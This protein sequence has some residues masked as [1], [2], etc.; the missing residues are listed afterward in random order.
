MEVLPLV[1][2]SYST[3][4][5][6]ARRRNP[7]SLDTVTEAAHGINDQLPPAN[8]NCEAVV[9]IPVYKEL[10][11]GRILTTLED[12]G[13]Q[14]VGSERFEVILV[15]NNPVQGDKT[16]SSMGE[17]DNR[18]LLMRLAFEKKGGRLGNVHAIDCTNGELPA[19]HIGLARGL[20][21]E[22]AQLRLKQTRK[23][24]QGIVVQLDADVAVD[25]DFMDLLITNYSQHPDAESA[26]IRRLPLPMDYISDDLYFGY[27][28]Y[29]MGDILS[30]LK[31]AGIIGASGPTIS[32]KSYLQQIGAIREY[33]D[34]PSNEDYL[35]GL[36]LSQNSR[37]YYFSEPVVYPGDRIRPEGYDANMRSVF[38]KDHLPSG[39]V[40]AAFAALRE[41]GYEVSQLSIPEDQYSLM[42][43]DELSEAVL[44][45]ME[46]AGLVQEYQHFLQREW[47]LI[48]S[49]MDW[50][51]IN[52]DLIKKGVLMFT[53]GRMLVGRE[54]ALSPREKPVETKEAHG[55]Y[56]GPQEDQSLP[57]LSKIKEEYQIRKE[58]FFIKNTLFPIKI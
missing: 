14:T 58:N 34:A 20:G 9:V 31:G 8:P 52:P 25:P 40:R 51:K 26:E 5:L 35:L 46:S 1:E 49:R 47:E 16:Y 22:V 29:C 11:D 13:R 37:F 12:L 18:L 50:D 43:I 4:L 38:I 21:A 2:S 53:L 55:L 10:R 3:L 41:Q 7:V 42:S 27:A 17:I 6:L 23:G 28:R 15:V 32:F 44:E 36:A 57:L 30:R 33:M 54:N 39:L 48:R 19:K 56:L 45:R 24:D